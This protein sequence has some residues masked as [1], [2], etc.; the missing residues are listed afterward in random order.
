MNEFEDKKLNSKLKIFSISA[1]TGKNME[2]FIDY[3]LEKVNSKLLK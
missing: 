1:K 3:L 2:E